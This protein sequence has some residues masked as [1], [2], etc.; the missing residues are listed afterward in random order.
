MPHHPRAP[1]LP[2]DAK[3]GQDQR[4]R[5]ATAER[6][7]RHGGEAKIWR[8]RILQTSAS[9]LKN[10][11]SNVNNHLKLKKS[12]NYN[13]LDVKNQKLISTENYWWNLHVVSTWNLHQL[14]LNSRP[15]LWKSMG[16]WWSDYGALKKIKGK[17]FGIFDSEIIWVAFPSTIEFNCFPTRITSELPFLLAF[18]CQVCLPKHYTSDPV[19]VAMTLLLLLISFQELPS[20]NQTWH[21]GKFPI[22]HFPRNLHGWSSHMF[23]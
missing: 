11:C 8:Q 4:H 9:E 7:E 10:S 19:P 12:L 18:N 17:P 3:E 21:A 5:R 2:P 15:N 22:D 20:A 13:C 6:A 14:G 16:E 1:R 23:I